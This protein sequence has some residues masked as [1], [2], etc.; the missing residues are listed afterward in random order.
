MDLNPL[1]SFS[2][3][4][5]SLHPAAEESSSFL[6]LYA[7]VFAVKELFDKEMDSITIQ[8]LTTPKEMQDMDTPTTIVEQM[9]S[10]ILI[11]RTEDIKPTELKSYLDNLYRSIFMELW[12]YKLVKTKRLS[13][14]E[15][16]REIFDGEDVTDME[17]EKAPHIQQGIVALMS[18]ILEYLESVDQVMNQVVETVQAPNE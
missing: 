12:F 17:D 3:V 8:V 14:S 11:V 15:D 6:A 18:S 2:H 7:T 9:G 5:V 10:I 16:G 1:A 4:P 13:M